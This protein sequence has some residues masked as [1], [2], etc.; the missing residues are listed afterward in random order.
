MQ[1]VNPFVGVGLR[2][3]KQLPLHCLGRVL[4]EVDH[5]EEQLVFNGWQ[6]TI[7]VGGV[8]TTDTVI[9]LDRLGLERVCKAG[10]KVWDEVLEFGAGEAGQGK[11]LCFILSNILIPEH[12]SSHLE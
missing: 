2:D 4:L 1:Q 7:A 9:S 12:E 3:A 6:R 5:D 11:E 8:R 10:R